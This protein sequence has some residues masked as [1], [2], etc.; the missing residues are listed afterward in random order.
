MA[1][2]AVFRVELLAR[3]GDIQV[4]VQETDFPVVPSSIQLWSPCCSSLAA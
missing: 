2:V 3:P 4:Q 1:T